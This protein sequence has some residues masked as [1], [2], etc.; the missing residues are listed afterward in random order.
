MPL[1]Y[2][3][4]LLARTKWHTKLHKNSVG[5]VEAMLSYSR[6]VLATFTKG[7]LVAQMDRSVAGSSL[8]EILTF[9]SAA[10]PVR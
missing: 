4:A 6:L 10:G 3:V 2:G 8:R 9:I 1:R 7:R 5:V